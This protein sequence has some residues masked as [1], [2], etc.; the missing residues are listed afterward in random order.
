MAVN[1]IEVIK[2]AKD[3][4][5]VLGDL[6][7]WASVED[8]PA[9]DLERLKW[10]GIFHRKTTPGFFMMRIRMPNGIATAEQAQAIAEIA[11]R[12]GRGQID[13]TTRQA[14]QL[15]W[16]QLADIPWILQRLGSAGL[17][18][19][20][21][22]M[23]NVRN[24]VGCPLAGLAHDEIIDTRRLAER[25][26]QAIIG[27]RDFSNLPRKFNISLTGCA[28]DCAHAQTH[29]LSFTTAERHGGT[30]SEFGFNVW[31]GGALGGQHPML[32]EALDAFVAPRDVV[33]IALAI[34]EV[35]RDHGFREKRQEARLKWLLQD[36][37][38]ER[39]RAAVEDRFGGP[40]NRAGESRV[41]THG[42]DHIGVE[43]QRQPGLHTVGLLVPVGR[44]TAEQLSMVAVLSKRY[45]SGEVR[46]TVQQNVLLP[47]VAA[48][49]LDALMAEPLLS[50][51][52]P[53]PSSFLRGLVSCTGNDYCHFSLIDTKGEALKLARALDERYEIDEPVR[54]QMS[55]C[56]HAC[57]LHRMADIGLQGDRVRI[58]GVIR[59]A[60]DV[61]VGGKI[62]LGA[63]LARP[64]AGG[65]PVEDLPALVASQIEE[66]RGPGGLRLRTAAPAPIAAPAEATPVLAS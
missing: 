3:G 31:V 12:C 30:T 38:I 1:K 62:G 37:G 18:S 59:D 51:L 66:L 65:V 46:L 21:S 4:L 20:Q 60:A 22:G 7:R 33:R 16:I 53:R 64:L 63:Q 10:Y 55:G 43:S 23:D 47:D 36:W 52:S 41:T 61:F 32:A 2:S 11:E 35:F 15:R 48:D 40:I 19:Q 24:V 34:L 25:L 58:D 14:V 9:D 45:G 6:Q 13:I 39:F 44:I 26:Q 29:D 49:D 50:D 42:G 28:Q 57:G 5:D 56:P 17:T 8:I 54:I 27:R